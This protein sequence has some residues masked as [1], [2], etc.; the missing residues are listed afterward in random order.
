MC[1]QKGN[2]SS[3]I[4]GLKGPGSRTANALIRRRMSQKPLEMRPIKEI[5]NI[6][7]RQSEVGK[8][9]FPGDHVKK[10]PFRPGNK[11]I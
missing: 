10:A 7:P 2:T 6:I 5:T 4:I 9:A 8:A 1:K 11:N 3:G